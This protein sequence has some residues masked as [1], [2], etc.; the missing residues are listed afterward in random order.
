MLLGKLNIDYVFSKNI[1][2]INQNGNANDL[3]DCLVISHELATLI[4][5]EWNSE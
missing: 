4:D 5:N 1:V 3:L 2:K